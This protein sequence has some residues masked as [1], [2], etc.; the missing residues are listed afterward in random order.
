MIGLLR[1]RDVGGTT[2]QKAINIGGVNKNI[3]SANRLEKVC[4]ITV[5]YTG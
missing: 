3:L 5:Q 1:D 4:T 2:D